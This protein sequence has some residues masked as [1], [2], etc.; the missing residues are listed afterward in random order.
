M[1]YQA[2]VLNSPTPSAAMMTII[3]TMM[4]DHPAWEFVEQVVSGANTA[5][6]YRNIGAVSH[7]CPGD[8]DFYVVI[9][10]PTDG[11]GS[12]YF[13]LCESWDAVGKLL[14]RYAPANSTTAGAGS[15]QVINADGSIGPTGQG[16]ASP[17]VLSATPAEA[18]LVNANTPYFIS[19][20]PHRICYAVRNVG[21]VYCGAYESLPGY[22]DPFPL[23]LM[24][25]GHT[26][27]MIGYHMN[28]DTTLQWRRQSGYTQG[29]T[30]G[31]AA[32]VSAALDLWCGSFTR[33]WR[34]TVQSA[35]G[36]AARP[37]IISQIVPTRGSGGLPYWNT[38][39]PLS[40]RFY[41]GRVGLNQAHFSLGAENWDVRGLLRDV[42]AQD[43]M[44]TY[45]ANGD[46]MVIE[47]VDHVCMCRSQQ[48][49]PGEHL[50]V[51][52]A[53]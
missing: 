4:L 1:S 23:L 25:N 16:F 5:R 38:R 17:N 10:R 45:P 21:W 30:G 19:L 53:A 28:A 46:S 12:I 39:E 2:G 24:V 43:P 50:W 13:Q 20:S 33:Q 27:P 26:A 18:L 36:W 34:T 3:D 32:S 37:F 42:F 48:S 49:Q 9:W 14:V 11:T 7:A 31:P 41:P 22:Y 51:S 29:S 52:K 35:T 40:G 47:G 6:V 8:A 44:D 15:Y